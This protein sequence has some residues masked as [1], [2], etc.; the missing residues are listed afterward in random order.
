M[1]SV[2]R[3]FTG[4]RRKL[5]SEFPSMRKYLEASGV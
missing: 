2:K 5:M 1:I 4:L 3:V